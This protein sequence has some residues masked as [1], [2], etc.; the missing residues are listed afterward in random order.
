MEH[1]EIK[2]IYR[3]KVRKGALG[4]VKGL[5]L[6]IGLVV[7]FVPL[8]WMISTSIKPMEFV[9]KIPPVW[10]PRSPTLK[11]F[12]DLISPTSLFPR[13]YINSI[14]VCFL[15]TVISMTCAVL[16]GYSFSRYKFHGSG[17]IFLFILGS[18]MFPAIMFLLSLYLMYARMRLLNNYVAL[19]IAY[20]SF[21]LPFA[22][23]ML[24]NYFDTI[25]LE[26]EEA[27]KVDGCNRF[28]ILTR[29][30][31]PLSAPALV[32][33]G[34]FTFLVAWNEMLFALTL[35]PNTESTT[36]PPGL[37]LTFVGQMTVSWGR[38]MAS[39]LLVT[40][41]AIALFIFLQRYVVQGLTGGAVK[42]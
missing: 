15:N 20:A 41:P 33:V 16:A 39:A 3:A 35:M 32:A 36:L 25:P 4:I 31:L 37:L 7:V 14:I 11:H 23:W 27:A 38:I 24:K 22:V 21:T 12:T 8:F 34:I 17:G 1:R 28:E 10:I 6:F 40:T 9:Y 5:V 2:W 18:Q 42:G 19:A 29:I 30:V 26:I 13:F